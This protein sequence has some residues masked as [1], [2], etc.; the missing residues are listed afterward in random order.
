VILSPT[1]VPPCADLG[2]YGPCRKDF[3]RGGSS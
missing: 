3:Y 1:A 2:W